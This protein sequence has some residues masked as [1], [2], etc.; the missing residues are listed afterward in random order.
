MSQ[1]QQFSNSDVQV[2]DS[3]NNNVVAPQVKLHADLQLNY[4]YFSFNST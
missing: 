3:A 4:Q 1:P 2:Q